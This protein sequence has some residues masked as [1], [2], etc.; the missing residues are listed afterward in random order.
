M[1][2]SGGSKKIGP[3]GLIKVGALMRPLLIMM[4]YLKIKTGLAERIILPSPKNKL[5][6]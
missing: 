2:T 4:P 1:C 3:I 5:C 6:I